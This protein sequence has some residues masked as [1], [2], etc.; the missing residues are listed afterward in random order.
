MASL[1]QL[2]FGFNCNILQS[3]QFTDESVQPARFFQRIDFDFADISVG[4]G[5]LNVLEKGI[6]D[7]AARYD[8][9]WQVAYKT[10]PKRMAVLVSKMDHCLYDL[11]IRQ[12]SGELRCQIPV[13]VSNHSDLKHVADMFGVNFVHLPI[14]KDTDAATAKA[15]QEAEVQRVLDD[16]DVDLTVLA[17]YMQIF[18]ADFCAKNWKRTIN[19]HHSFLPAFEVRAPACMPR[20]TFALLCLNYE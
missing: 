16:A 20:I 10:V 1:A 2:L 6:A 3:D 4:T 13:V 5:N 9:E 8:M 17:R 11:L 7:C 12:R 14:S 19:I 18:S 15:A